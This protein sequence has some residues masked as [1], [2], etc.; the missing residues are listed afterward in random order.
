MP[1]QIIN[2]WSHF[3]NECTNILSKFDKFSA[4]PHPIPVKDEV[5][6]VRISDQGREF[7]NQVNDKYN[8]VL[9]GDVIVFYF[10]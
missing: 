2:T 5:C 1:L 6:K 10:R 8:Y 3:Y 7:V 4:E 9:Y